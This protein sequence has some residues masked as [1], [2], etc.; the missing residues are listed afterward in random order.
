MKYRV[1]QVDNSIFKLQRYAL[2]YWADVTEP[3][4]DPYRK[5]SAKLF[6]SITEAEQYVKQ[7]HAEPKAKVVSEFDV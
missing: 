3:G 2:G 7:R 1:I 5:P 6:S 4:E